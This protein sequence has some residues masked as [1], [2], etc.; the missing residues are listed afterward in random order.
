MM[1][2]RQA[3]VGY[4]Q[5]TGRAIPDIY[6][7]EMGPNITDLEGQSLLRLADQL[8]AMLGDNYQKLREADNRGRRSPTPPPRRQ[9]LIELIEFVEQASIQLSDSGRY[10]REVALSGDL[11]AE[12]IT[13]ANVADRWHRHPAWPALRT[14]FASSTEAEHTIMLLAVASYLV[15]ANNGVGLHV[16]GERTGAKVADI[17]LEPDLNETVDLELKTPLA[18]RAPSSPLNPDSARKL[19]ERALKKSSRQRA[20]TRTSLLA[21]GGYHLGESFPQL[22]LAATRLLNEQRQRWRGLAGVLVVDCTYQ[23]GQSGSGPTNFTPILRV[24]FVAHPGYGGGITVAQDQ[25]AT[26]PLE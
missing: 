7:P 15:D 2:G 6:Q 4:A 20:N 24:E 1:V 26:T 13:A 21:L 23:S 10:M 14:T 11:L 25:L 22:H 3:L 12:S 16:H 5:E 18:I 8:R 19:V 9:R 17:W